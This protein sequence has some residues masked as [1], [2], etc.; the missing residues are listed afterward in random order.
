[1]NSLIALSDEEIDA[2]VQSVISHENSKMNLTDKKAQIEQ[3]QARVK[4]IDRMITKMYMDNAE[5]KISDDR[6]AR[7][8]PDLEKEA[9]ALEAKIAELDVDD[10][11]DEI[12]ENYE[13]FFALAKKHTYIETLDRDTLITF[14][15]RIEVGE[16]ILPEGYEKMPRKNASYQQSIRIFYKFIGEIVS[17]P[18]RDMVPAGLKVDDSPLVEGV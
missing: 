18:V 6:L 2:L 16:K 14:I 4:M 7:V 17:E 13:R 9:S 10:P 5:G 12:H 1:M 15:D 11:T 8:V 3:A